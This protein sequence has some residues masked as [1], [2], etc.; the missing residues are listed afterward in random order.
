MADSLPDMEF[1]AKHR[2]AVFSIVERAFTIEVK[3]STYDV[4]RSERQSL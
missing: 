1:S 3:Q 2:H 4:L